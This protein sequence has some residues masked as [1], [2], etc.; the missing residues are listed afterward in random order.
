MLIENIKILRREKGL[1]QRDLANLLSLS[2]NT[3]SNWENGI[4]EP[5][6]TQL[7]KISEVF[8]VSLSTLYGIDDSF[9]KS[10]WYDYFK[11]VTLEEFDFLMKEL[12]KYRANKKQN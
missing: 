9:E 6:V 2:Q 8:G 5:T 7:Q 10:I 4:T 1:T 11:D 3:V 12:K